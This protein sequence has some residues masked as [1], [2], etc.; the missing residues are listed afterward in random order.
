[1]HNAHRAG[2][3]VPQCFNTD[4]LISGAGAAGL[5]LAVELARRGANFRLIEKLGE[6][7]PGSRGKGIQPRTLEVFEDLS[8]V[9]RVVASGGVYPPQREYRDEGSYG[10]TQIFEASDPTSGEPYQIPLLV[11][12]F[13]TEAALRE[14]LT[15]LGHRAEFGCE[16][17]GFEQDGEG[18]TAT[19][20]SVKGE[21]TIRVR[22][23]VGTD[24]GRS[25]VRHALKI[26]FP[27]ET[28]GVRAVVAD[29]MVTG[30]SRNAWRR[31]NEGS[32]EK[33]ISLC[34]LAGTEMFQLQGPIP[35]QGDIDLSAGD[36]RRWSS[37]EPAAQTSR[38]SRSHGHP[39]SI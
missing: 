19:V 15:E 31:F 17:T 24:G 20:V 35:L 39:P 26:G 1:M 10:E 3:A 38:Y 21:E 11:P 18:V 33:Q 37:G 14:R 4:V 25:F 29:V 23:L 32:M 12:Q 22:Y 28:L 36:C 9:D 13:L 7:F 27:G 5:T 8:I 2:L 16:L 30:V 34:P 6:P